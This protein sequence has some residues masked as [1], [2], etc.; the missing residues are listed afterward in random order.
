MIHKSALMKLLQRIKLKMCNLLCIRV[1]AE[2]DIDS[3]EEMEL[4]VHMLM[5]Y[6]KYCLGH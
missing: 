6:I 4:Y 2:L 5:D 1:K 3:C